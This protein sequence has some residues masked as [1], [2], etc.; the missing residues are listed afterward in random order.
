[1]L[2]ENDVEKMIFDYT[3][4]PHASHGIQRAFDGLTAGFEEIPLLQF[5]GGQR[6]Q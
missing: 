6:K 4:R 5:W 1:M 2:A 3:K